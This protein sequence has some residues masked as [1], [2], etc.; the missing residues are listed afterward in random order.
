MLK[1]LLEHP[2]LEEGERK[3]LEREEVMSEA[4]D[5]FEIVAEGHG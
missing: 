2:P 3:E 5:S 1:R 4:T